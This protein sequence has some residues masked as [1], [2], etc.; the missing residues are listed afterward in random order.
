MAFG[1]VRLARICRNE[2]DAFPAVGDDVEYLQ[3]SLVETGGPG[4]KPRNN[5]Q[6]CPSLKLRRGQSYARPANNEGKLLA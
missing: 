5:E 1:A 4:E 6:W 3:L 2:S